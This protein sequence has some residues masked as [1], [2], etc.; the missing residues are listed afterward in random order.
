MNLLIL[1]KLGTSISNIV[2][3]VETQQASS[4]GINKKAI[5]MFFVQEAYNDAGLNVT[6]GDF[7]KVSVQVSTF[8]DTVVAIYRVLGKFVKRTPVD[9]APDITTPVT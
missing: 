3:E 1:L 5:A 8:I 4:T 7:D 6:V 2:K 9:V